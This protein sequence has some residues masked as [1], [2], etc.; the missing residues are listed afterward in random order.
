[1]GW[2]A[3]VNPGVMGSMPR[4]VVAIAVVVVAAALVGAIPVAAASTPDLVPFTDTG[5][6]YF[7]DDTTDQILKAN[8]AGQVSIVVTKQQQ[9]QAIP[10]TTLAEMVEPSLA[11]DGES[12]LYWMVRLRISNVDRYTLFRWRPATGNVEVVTTAQQIEAATRVKGAQAQ[13]FAIAPDG[14]IYLAEETA[15]AVVAI[16]STTGEALLFASNAALRAVVPGSPVSLDAPPVVDA[17]GNVHVPNEHE[18][19][20]FFTITPAGVVSALADKVN[21]IQAIA[22]TATGGTFQLTFNGEQTAPIAR[23]ASR[24]NIKAAIE[25]LASIDQVRVTGAGTT[26]GPWLVEFRGSLA[27]ADVAPMTILASGLTP[28]GSTAT[29]TTAVNGGDLGDVDTFVTLDYAG[30]ITMIDDVFHWIMTRTLDGYVSSLFTRY[31]LEAANGD[32]VSLDS[33]LAW[34]DDGSLYLIEDHRDRIYRITPD[35]TFT[36]F[37]VGAQVRAATGQTVHEFEGGLAFAN[38]AA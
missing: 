1:M 35:G 32:V 21:E 3:P 34:A 13:N 9:L 6:L 5:D 25:A 16:N 7:V 12:S 20:E 19:S 22:T 30:R 2:R 29:V 17:A 37:L 14:T 28:E 36:R 18:P 15:D 26:A 4:R 31:Q 33:G 23:T 10:N 27:D 24:V 38:G 11:F 8:A